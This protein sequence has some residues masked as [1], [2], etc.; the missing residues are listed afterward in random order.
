MK[1]IEG[2]TTEP[3]GLPLMGDAWV[4]YLLWA[5]QDTGILMEFTAD[6]GMNLEALH[7]QGINRMIDEATGFQRATLI[8]F[9]DWVTTNYWGIE[10]DEPTEAV[11]VR[12]DSGTA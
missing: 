8:A 5:A 11:G 7:S 3:Y 2:M 10:G 9:A 12:K 4:S 6:T 1:P